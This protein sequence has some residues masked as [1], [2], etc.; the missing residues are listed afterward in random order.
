MRQRIGVIRLAHGVV[1]LFYPLPFMFIVSFFRSAL[2]PLFL[3]AFVLGAVAAIAQSPSA[4]DGFDPNVDGN[5]YAMVTQPDGKIIVAGQFSLFRPALGPAITRRNIARINPDGSIDTAFNPNVDPDGT[6][7]SGAVRAIALQADGRIVIGGDFNVIKPG[8]D[9]GTKVTCN[10]IARLN[11]DG[12]VDGSFTASFAALTNAEVKANPFLTILDQA[13]PQI[14]ALAI[15]PNGKIIVGGRFTSVWPNVV[16]RHLARLNL[17]GS[18]DTSYF[19]N[20]NA[21]VLA[22]AIQLAPSDFTGANRTPT[23]DG[24]VIVGGGFTNF[25]TIGPDNKASL[26]QRKRIARINA[27][28]VVDSEFDPNADNAVTALAIQ[29]DGKIVLGGAFTTLSPVGNTSPGADPQFATRNHVAR[30]NADG[31]LDSEFYPNVGGNV[32]SVGIA[33]DGGILVGGYF[34]A[35]W[36]RGAATTARAYVARIAPDGSIDTNFNAGAN[37]A[38]AAFGFQSD[39]KILL[40][41]Y[42]TGLQSRGFGTSVVRN[43]LAR[44]NPD[45]ALDA[46]LSLDENGGRPL[47]TFI[48]SDGKMLIGGSFTSVGGQTRN[49][50]ARLNANGSLDA[51]FKPANLNGRVLSIAVQSDGKIVIGGVFTVVGTEQR[52][53]LA[54]LGADGVLDTSFYPNPNSQVGI[55]KIVDGKILVAGSF[56][57][58]EPNPGASGSTVTARGYIAKINT[59]GTLDSFDPGAN[60]TVSSIVLMDGGKMMLGGAFTAFTPNAGTSTT[61]RNFIAKLNSDG[62]V[63]TGF[64]PTINGRVTTVVVQSDGKVIAGGQFT[65]FLPAGATDVTTQAITRNRLIRFNADGTLDTAYEPNVINGTVLDIALQRDGKIVIGGSFNGFLSKG[66]STWTLVKYAARVNTDGTLDKAFNLDISEASGNRV[67]SITLQPVGT[68]DKIILGGAFTSIQNVGAARV[69]VNRYARINGDGVLD[70]TFVPAVSG[71]TSGTISSLAVQSDGK[72]VAVGSFTDIGG[73]RTTNIARFNPEGTADSGFS[74][75]LDA[76]GA[77][78]AVLHRPNIAAVTTQGTGYAWLNHDGSLRTTYAPSARLNGQFKAVAVQSDGTLFLGGSFVDPATEVIKNFVRILPNGVIDDTNFISSPDGEVACIAIQKDGKILIGGSFTGISAGRT[79]GAGFTRNYIAR[80]NTDGT[81]DSTFNPTADARVN[82]IV[83][84]GD[85]KIII[86]GAFTTLQ[87]NGATSSTTHSY[88]ARLNS[89]GTLDTDYTPA[90]STTV[91]ALLLESDERL[92]VGGAFTSI[93]PKGTSTAS[94]RNYIARLNK[95]GTLDTFDPSASGTVSSLA[96]W[97]DG[98]IIVGGSFNAFSPNSVG[99]TTIRNYIA[100]LNTDGTVDANFNP[101]ANN[102]VNSVAVDPSDATVVFGGT[103]TAVQPN[104]STGKTTLE[105]VVRNRVARV[106]FDGVL[107]VSFNPDANGLVSAIAIGPNGSVIIGGALSTVRPNGVMFVGGEFKTLGESTAPYLA[108]VNDDGT[109][110]SAFAPNPDQA[111]TSLLSLPD[112]SMLVGGK[113]TKIGGVARNRVA[114]FLADNTLD[115]SY[116]PNVNGD[117]NVLAAHTNNRVLIGGAFTTV[118]GTARANLARLNPDGTTD[119]TFT[120]SVTAVRAFAVQADGRILVLLT[121]GS[122]IRLNESGSVD[123]TFATFSGGSAAVSAIALQSDGRVLVGGAFTGFLKRLNANGTVDTTFDP[124]PDGAVTALAL[125]MDGRPILG[126]SFGKVGGY[127]RGGLARLGASTPATQNF[128]LNSA[129]TVITWSR[130]GTGTELSS[131]NFYRSDDAITWTRLG[132]AA[133]VG[134]TGG[135]N[136]WQLTVPALPA[137]G[138]FYLSARAVVST[139]GISSGLAESTRELNRTNVLFGDVNLLPAST[140]NPATDGSNGGTPPSSPVAGFR[141]L[142]D[143]AGLNQAV[144]AAQAA[145]TPGSEKLAHLINLS[146]RTRVAADNVLLTGFA[147]NGTG[148]RTVLV[149]AVGPGLTGFGV[150]GALSAPVLRIY[151]G[152]GNALADNSGWANSAVLAQAASMSG[153]FPL[154][155]G[156]ADAALLVTL[157]PGTY[158]IQVLDNSGTGG[159]ALAEVYDVAGG[160]T[161]RLANVSSRSNAGSGADALISGFVIAG[162]GNS[163]E[164][165]LVRGVGPALT[166]FGVTSVLSDPKLGVYRGDI[167]IASNDNWS[168]T[169]SDGTATLTA[170]ALSVGAFALPMGSK[171][172]ALSVSLAPGAYT[173]QVTAAS[174]SAG[175]ALLEIY[176]LK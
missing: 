147:I 73:T 47:V 87:P 123:S 1:A 79:G 26:T 34:T 114:L 78:S 74:S 81:V 149:R 16:V 13:E 136:A 66:D 144:A 70:T 15:Q 85:G 60:S 98:K 44:V 46:T 175:G 159:V 82:A 131:V 118:N 126:G 32:I 111:V 5:V 148:E 54:R 102:T 19:P 172:A 141:I 107:D 20:P 12:T 174:E 41:G 157:A 83:V 153:A 18:V 28:G 166:Q 25:E 61:T 170:N 42:F 134:G 129:G 121:A 113:F 135:T 53:Y 119:S 105:P 17:N 106:G 140:G 49:Y 158:S 21:P 124:Q 169:T 100:R 164:K 154:A 156:S 69:A 75:S 165:V 145:T 142:A 90:A 22:L 155:P 161:S 50:L 110:S 160:S 101:N 52:N 176:E 163:N 138:N 30:L 146:T 173:A 48:Q 88:I 40:G 108:L 36:G 71:G 76:T 116:Q 96:L 57:A 31:T 103:F 7:D 128:S 11:A 45:G 125:Q 14:N 9:T 139:G 64:S 168:Q 23:G 97:I 152:A 51:N 130:G 68:E 56:T 109:V 72:I 35:V 171:D 132:V 122:L 92:I 99:I 150:S 59:D 29:R 24:R 84:Q 27:N 95:D 8:G 120:A 133:R 39:G 167:V 63:D 91:N 2:R 89:D 38:V 104:D 65:Q 162:D 80:F 67:D 62:K 33:N 3:S 115:T 151:D 55:V 86:G 77:V 10:R 58:F 112:G 4:S 6:K 43:H 37:S 143:L 93:T 137:S 117:V 127:S 94:V